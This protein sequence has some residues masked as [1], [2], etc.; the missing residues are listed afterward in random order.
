M[1][2]YI[3]VFCLLVGLTQLIG[4]SIRLVNSK[5]TSKYSKGLNRYFAIVIGYIL[6]YLMITYVHNAWIEVDHFLMLFMPIIPI[7]IAIYY[8][9]VVYTFDKTEIE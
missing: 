7:C 8:W 9:I 6:S 5:H 2:A 1:N 4:G 3:L